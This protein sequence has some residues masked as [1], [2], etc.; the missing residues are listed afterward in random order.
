MLTD[1]THERRC[2]SPRQQYRRESSCECLI[3]AQVIA[4]KCGPR[5]R[6]E[7]KQPADGDGARQQPLRKL[8]PE[9]RPVSGNHH[10]REVAARRMSTADYSSRINIERTRIV[11][12]PG[13]GTPH[14]RDDLHHR[15][16]GGQPVVDHRNR[17]ARS[18]IL[19]CNPGE[20][21]L[22]ERPPVA[23]VHEYQQRIRSPP[24]REQIQ[25][26]GGC[27]AVSQVQA[28]PHVCA[29][30]LR[31]LLPSREEAGELRHLGPGVV[32]PIQKLSFRCPGLHDPR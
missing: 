19:G 7:I 18:N 10:C 8:R 22:V 6:L 24:R 4:Q 30:L 9:A 21:I 13:T 3:E 2:V 1:G 26:L 23:A 12:Q 28:S 11:M 20:V 5:Q 27:R 17:N 15:G 16:G 14:L 25:P 32:F 31:V 29:H